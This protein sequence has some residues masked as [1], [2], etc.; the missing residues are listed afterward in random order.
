MTQNELAFP[1]LGGGSDMIGGTG[2]PV[3]LAAAINQAWD[4]ARNEAAVTQ[5]R[6]G[7]HMQ[8]WR[9][10]TNPSCY[11]HKSRATGRNES[12]GWITVGPD[13]HTDA[14]EHARYIN[15]KHM[16]PLPQYGSMPYGELGAA[17]PQLRFKQIIEK[18]GLHEFPVDQIR[19]YNW[20]KIPEV[21]GARPEVATQRISCELGGCFGRDF[22]TDEGYRQHVQAV[23]SKVEGTEAMTRALKGAA[24][25]DPAAI[26]AAVATAMATIMPEMM[27]IFAQRMGMPA[28]ST[29]PLVTKGGKG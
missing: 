25:T 2:S 18:G 20:D 23:H 26:A 29:E 19:A 16:T 4:P 17:N 24:Q 11:K 8:Y 7:A 21:V 6:R 3:E 5:S 12:L 9:M 1:S 27:N 10:C 15:T 13:L 28:I 14:L 22:L